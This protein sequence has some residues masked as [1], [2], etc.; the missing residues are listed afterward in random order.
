MKGRRKQ[1][2]NQQ[3]SDTVTKNF[4]IP[5]FRRSWE[6]YWPVLLHKAEMCDGGTRERERERERSQERK[7]SREREK[8][9]ER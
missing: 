6:G 3:E 5:D 2:R 1:G 4:I 9:R 8:E 7:E